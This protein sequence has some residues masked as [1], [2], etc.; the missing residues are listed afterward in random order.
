MSMREFTGFQYVQIDVANNHFGGLDKLIFEERLA[1]V[2]RHMDSLEQEA[3]GRIWKERP[4]YLKAVSALRKAQ[5]GI[6]SGHLVGMDAVCSGL[7]IMSA[8]TGCEIGANA[9]GLV[10]PDRRAD[11]YTDC[12]NLMADELGYHIKGEREKIKQSVMTSLY[13]SK[14]EP[15]KEFGEDTPELYAFYK[16][17]YKLCPGACDL[18]DILV[19]SWKPFASVQS[20]KLP[21]GFDA[22]VK[23]MQQKEAKLEIDELNHTTCTYTWFE[24]EGKS[25]DVKNCANV[26]H[27]LDSYILRSLIRRC[28]YDRELVTWCNFR[29]QD[30][31]RY[32]K[33]GGSPELHWRADDSQ[34]SYY[35]QQYERSS[36]ADIVILPYLYDDAVRALSTEHIQGL[37]RI[38]ETMLVHQPFEVV[39]IHDCFAAH[40]N[41]INYLRNH[42][43]N[44]LA[45]LADSHVLDDILSQLYGVKGTFPKRSQNLGDTIRKSAYAIC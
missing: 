27:S 33:H 20:W 5:K 16:A 21:D 15:K 40:P 42:Y 41:N 6:S 32:R 12:T 31:L 28:N 26:V 8:L 1:W 4:M 37:V 9:A 45:D 11:A 25:S 14:A 17:M 22:R 38:T 24:N 2:D 23:V 18:L 43:R 34:L 13:G 35:I 36:V 39:T 3:E 7:Q 19:N 10:D 30:E 44:I 29:F